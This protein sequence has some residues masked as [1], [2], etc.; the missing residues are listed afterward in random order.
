MRFFIYFF[1]F[2]I[3]VVLLDNVRFCVEFRGEGVGGRERGGGGGGG[4]RLKMISSGYL[5]DCFVFFFDVYEEACKF[6]LTRFVGISSSSS[7]SLYHH[8]LLNRN[9]VIKRQIRHPARQLKVPLL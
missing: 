6:F 5:F 1:F 3:F 9:P 4:R 2:Q 8:H 7:S